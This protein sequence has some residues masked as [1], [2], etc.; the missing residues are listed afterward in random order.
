[1]ISPR[2]KC[3]NLLITP[4]VFIFHIFNLAIIAYKSARVS[5]LS[6]LLN[7]VLSFFLDIRTSTFTL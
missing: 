5:G 3:F 6:I 4:K 1:M 7:R 2:K